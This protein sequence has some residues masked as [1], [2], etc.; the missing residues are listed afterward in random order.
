MTPAKKYPC[1]AKKQNVFSLSAKESGILA[2][3]LE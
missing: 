3:E 2:T 1:A